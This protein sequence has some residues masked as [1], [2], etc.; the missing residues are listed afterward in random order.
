MAKHAHNHLLL[1]AEGTGGTQGTAVALC[2]YEQSPEE[3]SLGEPGNLLQPE[4]PTYNMPETLLEP[5]IDRPEFRSHDGWFLLHGHKHRPGLYWHTW[6]KPKGDAEPEPIDEWICT[7]IHSDAITANERGESF[8]LLLR[9]MNPNGM[10]REWAAPMHL[11]KGSAEELRGE[12]LNMGVRIDPKNRGLLAKWMMASYPKSRIIAALRTGWH[13]ESFVLPQRTIGA[14]NIRFQSEHAAHND[15]VAAGTLAGWQKK[16]AALCRG[17]PLLLLAVSASFTGPLLKRTKLQETGGAGIH[18]VGDSSQGKSTGLQVAGSTWGAPG[19]VRTWRATSNGLEATAAALNDTLLVLDEI[20]ECDPRD[21]GAIVYSLAN[22][23]G[24][25]RASRT[26]GTR[27]SARWR[28][29]AL[30]SGE[31]SLSTH[32]AEGGK[33]AKAGQEARLLDVPAT[34]RTHGLFDTLH[35]HPNGRTFADTL[36]QETG[37]H[38]GH[39]GPAF[40]EA[41]V[42]DKRDLPALYAKAC[43]LPWLTGRDGLENRAGS[44]FALLGMAGELATEYGITGWEEGEAMSAA[45]LAFKMWRD[46][47]GQGQTE[48]RQILHAIKNFI[49]RNGDARFSSVF[50]ENIP[51]RERAGYWKDSTEGRI[52]LFNSPALQEAASGFELRRILTALE[53]AGWIIEHDIG[54]R[55]KKVKVAGSSV[56]L[57]AI[58]P[59]DGDKS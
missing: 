20:S 7:P 1:N 12:L 59:D 3:N 21:I 8:G 6:S 54:K 40:V 18:L 53:S 51:I 57:Y 10:W 5:E 58:R 29:I 33:Q 30:S 37:N 14:K 16:V 31:R 25:Q 32:M 24:K 28:I 50:N 39:A 26:G 41:L 42:R 49:L 52:Y 13:D 27:E 38:Y 34:A 35:G 9:F 48:N 46:F 11:L 17:N 22:G 56:S 15:F 19:F 23:M 47:R 43:N 45:L 36:K 4:N 2:E 55:S 44:V